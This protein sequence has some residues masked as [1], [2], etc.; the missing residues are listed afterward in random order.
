MAID[1]IDD[2]ITS[3]VEHLN[4][5]KIA[6]SIVL[7]NKALSTCPDSARSWY[8]LGLAHLRLNHDTQALFCFDRA[9]A[10]HPTPVNA[11]VSKGNLLLRHALYKKAGDMYDCAL[12]LNPHNKEAWWNKALLF[13]ILGLPNER[14]S[15]LVVL[16]QEFGLHPPFDEFKKTH[17]AEHPRSGTAMVSFPYVY[18]GQ[19][20]FVPFTI[21][22]TISARCIRTRPVMYFGQ[23]IAQYYKKVIADRSQKRYLAPL[24]DAILKRAKGDPDIAARYAISL[25]QL[26]PYRHINRIH[27]RTFFPYEVLYNQ[28]GVCGNKSILLAAV[29]K[30]LGFGSALFLYES[31]FHMA[32]G[33]RAPKEYC[34]RKTGYAFIE[35]TRPNLI[36]D[37]ERTYRDVGR[38]TSIPKVIPVSRGQA[39]GDLSEEAEDVIEYQRILALGQVVDRATYDRWEQLNKKYGLELYQ[40]LPE[41]GS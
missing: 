1:G 15:C 33:I 4:Q 36:T 3:G 28:R 11:Y 23:S 38:L 20:D 9:I 31:E 8:N 6:E 16:K 27:D 39:I 26:I 32:V 10:L 13:H 30:G 35:S 40:D 7:F 41:S 18:H 19:M 29:L 17:F 24:V 25:V 5:G 37:S 2:L 21:S 34:Y 22:E 12:R 14:D